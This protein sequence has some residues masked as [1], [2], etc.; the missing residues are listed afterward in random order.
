MGNAQ[1]PFQNDHKKVLCVCS[2]GLLRSPTAAVVL[3]QPPYNFNTRAVGCVTEY[4]LIPIDEVLVEWADEIVCMEQS[5]VDRI[6]RDILHSGSKT[7]VVLGIPDRFPY[8]DPE[9][10]EAIKASY[11]AKRPDNR[12]SSEN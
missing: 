12:N 8:R 4:A 5:H 6:Q 10:V 9:L 11:D 3:S 2:A 7:F 1:N